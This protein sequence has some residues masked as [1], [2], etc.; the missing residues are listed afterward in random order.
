MRTLM[1]D[2]YT[3]PMYHVYLEA[4]A[5]YILWL[6]AMFVLRDKARRI[7]SVIGLILSIVLILLFTVS[8]RKSGSYDIS[9]IPFISFENAKTNT[10]LYR[11]MFMNLLLFIPLG[12]CMPFALPKKVKIKGLLTIGAGMVLS[13][14]IEAIQFFFSLGRC[15]TDDVIMNTT[16]VI[17]GTSVYLFFFLVQTIKR[18]RRTK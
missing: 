2:Y 8:G 10:E 3:Q 7:I 4:I 15:E 14:A 18:K 9:L 16:G 17:I 12:L 5:M 13:I 6:I 1:H 11:S